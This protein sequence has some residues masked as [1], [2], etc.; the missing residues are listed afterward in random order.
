MK[1]FAL[2][3][4]EHAVIAHIY[5][6]KSTIFVV[7]LQTHVCLRRANVEMQHLAS[8]RERY[9]ILHII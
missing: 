1:H 3:S 5:G 2:F 8:V 9:D 6:G 4:F 7:T